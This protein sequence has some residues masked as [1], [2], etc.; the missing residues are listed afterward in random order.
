M[1]KRYTGV[2]VTPWKLVDYTG[3]VLRDNKGR[4]L[5]GYNGFKQAK[6]AGFGYEVAIPVRQ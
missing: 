6:E 4:P 5:Q 3:K 2:D 1:A